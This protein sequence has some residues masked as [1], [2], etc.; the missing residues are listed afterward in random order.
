MASGFYV[1][2]IVSVPTGRTNT[3]DK[4]LTW[5]NSSWTHS[6][7]ENWELQIM[8][9]W[10]AISSMPKSWQPPR[11]ATVESRI[12]IID[13]RYLIASFFQGHLMRQNVFL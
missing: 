13:H 6:L 4:M 3:L 9:K 10:V 8:K 11:K 7:L 2:Q 1:R 12:A 5:K